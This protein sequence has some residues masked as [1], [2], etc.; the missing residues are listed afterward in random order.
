MVAQLREEVTHRLQAEA[1]LKESEARLRHL[2]S[3]LLEAQEKERKRLAAELHDELGH[4]LLTIKLQLRALAR[5]LTRSRKRWP[6]TSRSCSP[7]STA[8]WTTC[9]VCIS[10]SA[11]AI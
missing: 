4:A 1:S 8:C 6:R 5:S 10:T 3:R 9:A 2:S 7:S 11:R